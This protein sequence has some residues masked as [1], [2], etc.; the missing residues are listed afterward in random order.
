VVELGGTL[1]TI[2]NPL[3]PVAQIGT[4]SPSAD[5]TAWQLTWQGWRGGVVPRHDTHRLSDDTANP[6]AAAMAAGRRQPS[7]LPGTQ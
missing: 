3:W 7:C 2:G 4:V 5:I 1:A 6:L